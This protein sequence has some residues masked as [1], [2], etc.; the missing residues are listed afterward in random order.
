MKGH[1]G[2]EIIGHRGAS[3]HAPENTETAILAGVRLGAT[4]IEVDVQFTA[5]GVPV[6]FHDRTLERMAGVKARI[7]DNTIR[8]LSGYDIGFR[9]GDEHR[10]LRILTLDEA[11]ALVPRGMEIH[12]EVKEYD[13]VEAALLKGLLG[14]LERRGGLDRCLFS[15]FSEK[16][17]TTLRDLD[18]RIRRALLVAGRDKAA[19]KRA[20]DLGC[21]ALNPEAS[22]VDAAL[23]EACHHRRMKVF[24][25]TV[26]EPSL[27]RTL[28]SLG[29]D[30]VY[31]DFPGRMA[32]LARP[33]A[34][35]R[36]AGRHTETA[37][38][39]AF[40]EPPAA[41]EEESGQPLPSPDRSEP[42]LGRALEDPDL[43]KKKRRRGKRGG[44]RVKERESRRPRGGAPEA[45]APGA[46]APGALA[47]EEP[48]PPPDLLPEGDGAAG[49]S[50]PQKKKRRR[51]K[52]GGRRVRERQMRR[53]KKAPQAPGA[54]AGGTASDDDTDGVFDLDEDS[55]G[56]AP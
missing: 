45:A 7:R 35:P 11:A 39:S 15:S 23:V 9:S 54:G 14:V 16:I 17:L 27:A 22:Q 47:G 28:M 21:A 13:P 8:D 40:E 26:N 6:V 49:A 18:G 1:A 4:S 55:E 53:E 25:Y 36:R 43:S 31:T 19:A 41:L 50:E 12:V 2:F 20:A 48:S 30:G 38:G 24:P 32:D 34:A 5:D 44:R 56:E 52:R 29:A 46:V 33:A 10:G 37:I 42:H 3:G 51:G